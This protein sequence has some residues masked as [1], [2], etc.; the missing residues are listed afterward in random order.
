MESFG[1]LD[2]ETVSVLDRAAFL[3]VIRSA[4][5]LGTN[6]PASVFGSR[7][8]VPTTRSSSMRD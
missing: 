4:L 1:S 7:G 5:P 6:E 8:E 2:R 3:M